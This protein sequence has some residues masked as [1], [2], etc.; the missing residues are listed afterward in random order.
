VQTNAFTY[1]FSDVPSG[2]TN[3]TVCVGNDS[4]MAGPLELYLR[5]GNPPTATAWDQTLTVGPAGGCLSLNF[6][7]LPPLSAGRYFIAVFNPG[8]TPQTI[9][10][11]ASV[12]V[13]TNTV[14]PSTYSAAR[15]VPIGDDALTY[16]RLLVTNTQPIASVAA[17]LHVDHPRISDMAF[18]LISPAGTRVSLCQNRGGSSVSGLGGTVLVTN[19]PT[20]RVEGGYQATTNVFNVGQNQGTLFVSYDMYNEPDDM[21]VYYDG[22]LLYDTGLVPSMNSFSLPFGPGVS[23]NL[24]IVMNEGDNANTNTLW[25]Y[26]A[27]VACPARGYVWFTENTN[28]A[29][30]PIKFAPSPFVPTG[31]STDLFYLPEESLAAFVGQNPLGEWQ[32]EMSD[33]RAGATNPPPQLAIWQLRFTFQNTVPAP[34]GLTYANP[35]TN[36]IPPDQVAPFFVDVPVWATRGTN[37][38]LYASAQVNLLFNQTNPPAGTNAGDTMLVSTTTGGFATLSTGGTPPLVPG[39]RYYL[40]VQ[41]PGTSNVIAALE[42]VFDKFVTPLTDGVPFANANSGAGD[43][44][45]YYLYT[46]STNAVRAQF[47]I[48]GPSADMT[49]VARKGLPPPTLTN[50]SY[51]SANPATNDELIV[52]FNSSSPVPLTAGTWYISAVNVSGEPATYA[53]RATEFPVY[54]TNIVITDWQASSSSLC[55]TWNA[56]AGVEYYVQGKTGVTDTNWVTLSPT[57]T[58]ADVTATYCVPLPS[59]YS[60]FRVHEGLVV[61]PVIVPVRI[62]SIGVSTNGVLL[63][64]TTP[65]SNQCQVQWTASLVPPAWNTLTNMITQ[66]NGAAS[67]LDDGSQ[68]GGLGGPRYYRLVQLP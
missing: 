6:S 21:R 4:P 43:A 64:W 53:V 62:T 31:A 68:T 9:R 60:F 55:L 39:A 58:A 8:D 49:L 17:R 33:T 11:D 12:A 20:T 57:V 29:Q 30:V 2:V 24:V 28:L 46:V 37:I 18:T 1:D 34:I 56:L 51:I 42:I 25:E 45:D 16:A 38:V 5:R 26:T 36:T 41:N 66:T 59:P 61:V 63:A 23:T 48:N 10:I 27:T 3:L 22:T 54:G 52:L 67:F 15:P 13:D 65:A 14:V 50:Y 44:T 40:G 7:D 19:I 32:L 35:G 47:E